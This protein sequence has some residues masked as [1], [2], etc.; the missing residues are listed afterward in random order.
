[1]H[2]ILLF[3]AAPVIDNF[4]TIYPPS[5]DIF[6]TQNGSNVLT[7]K[8]IIKGAILLI[9]TSR[10]E[11]LKHQMT[12]PELKWGMANCPD[13]ATVS[14]TEPDIDF[15]PATASA[16]AFE[17]FETRLAARDAERKKAAEE[18]AKTAMSVTSSLEL[19][20]SVRMAG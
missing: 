18:A 11:R 9:H 1:M 12:H 13:E 4:A 5:C 20:E 2:S 3:I 15:I 6:Y 17:S 7:T 19:G 16:A 14:V 10:Y 8:R